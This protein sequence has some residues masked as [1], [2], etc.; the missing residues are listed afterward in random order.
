MALQNVLL[1]SL[2]IGSLLA[3][4]LA[5][6]SWLSP[7]KSWFLE[8]SV[9]F[10][11]KTRPRVF[12]WRDLLVSLSNLFGSANTKSS[13][14][15]QLSSASSYGPIDDLSYKFF[16]LI[17]TF[18]FIFTV[19]VRGLY[20]LYWFFLSYPTKIPCQDRSSHFYLFF[21]GICTRAHEPKIR[22]CCKSGLSHLSFS[23]GVKQSEPE[24]R[25]LR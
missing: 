13:L 18:L 1:V 24:L 17:L 12:F 20:I 11:E 6:C 9:L 15:D 23:K 10:D 19:P 3:S 22:R 8:D 14:K 21:L 4:S 2:I 7:I 16:S 5:D 25:F